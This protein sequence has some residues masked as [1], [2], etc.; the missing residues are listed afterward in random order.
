MGHVII[1]VKTKLCSLIYSLS[2]SLQTTEEILQSFAALSPVTDIQRAPS[3]FV[4]TSGAAVPDTM[5]WREKGCVTSV[6]M[7]V[8]TTM[9]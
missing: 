3:S 9:S 7:Q 6:K 2:T 5:D 4:R 8:K 1:W